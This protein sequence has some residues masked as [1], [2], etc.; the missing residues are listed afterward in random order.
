MSDFNLNLKQRRPLWKEILVFAATT[1][2]LWG[3]VHVFL[4]YDAFAEIAKFKIGLLKTSVLETASTQKEVIT[5]ENTSPEPK[6]VRLKKIK[7]KR[8]VFRNKKL[9]PKNQ[10]KE[11]FREMPVYPSDNRLIIPRIGKNVP[12]IEVPN[13]KNWYQLETNIQDGLRGGVVVH[14]ISH[15]PGTVGNF[16]ATGH[17][18][19]YK[20]DSGRFKDVF[21]LLHEV[22]IG[23]TVIV[24]WDG[25]K[26][27]YKMHE[28]KVV[29]PTEISVLNHPTNKAILTLMTCTPI[30]TNKDRLILVGTLK[31]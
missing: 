5:E 23:D 13:H 1:V 4:N 20:W 22:K 6:L 12:L 2:G 15:A 31:Q 18:S 29:P 7:R 25:Q 26:F 24:Y 27:E 8:T 16:F 9:K 28:Q 21:A 17:S 3:G 11:I 14:P 10:I 30:G 19:Y